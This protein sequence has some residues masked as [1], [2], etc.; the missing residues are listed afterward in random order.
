MSNPPTEIGERRPASVRVP[1]NYTTSTRYPLVVVLHGFGAN[2]RLQSGYLGL[3]RR[4]DERQYILLFPDG[5]PNSAGALFWN[6][7]SCCAPSDDRG[8]VDDVAYLRELIA[9]A[10]LHFSIDTRRVGLIGH[11]NGG[12]M[13]LRMVCEASD[14]VTAAVSLAGWTFAEDALCSPADNPVRVLI[15][16]GTEDETIEYDGAAF[17]ED[18]AYPGAEETT[19]RFAAHAGCDSSAPVTAANRDVDAGIAGAETQV[20]HYK[21]CPQGIHVDLWTMVDSPHIPAPWVDSAIDAIVTWIV[22]HPRA[23]Q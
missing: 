9:T 5:T 2:G 13:T 20:L 11:S 17:S 16:H 23:S 3:D 8:R 4:V 6:A 18:E 1:S 22:D 10:A 14:L 15:M 19:R 7:P 12:A 21:G